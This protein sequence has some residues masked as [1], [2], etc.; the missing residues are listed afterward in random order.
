[1]EWISHTVTKTMHAVLEIAYY[2][3][4]ADDGRRDKHIAHS[5]SRYVLLKAKAVQSG[6]NIF[7]SWQ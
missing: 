7:N 2:C 3:C 4:T 6:C 1:M 5:S